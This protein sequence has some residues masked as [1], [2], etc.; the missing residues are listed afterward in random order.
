MPPTKYKPKY[1][2][3]IAFH[4][5]AALWHPKQGFII[6]KS[7]RAVHVVVSLGQGFFSNYLFFFFFLT[8]PT[9]GSD[10]VLLKTLSTC[11]LCFRSRHRL[12]NFK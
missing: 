5:A 8:A 7:C 12:S 11:D 9:P 3:W 1:I 2:Y 4:I 10:T 6:S